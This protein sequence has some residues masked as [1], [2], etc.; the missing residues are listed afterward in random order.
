ME[1][2]LAYLDSGLAAKGWTQYRL[3]QEVKIST[4]AFYRL[5]YGVGQGGM[6]EENLRRVAQA[7]DLDADRLVVL[8]GALYKPNSLRWNYSKLLGENIA[9]RAEL[10][11]LRSGTEALAS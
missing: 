3:A 4:T 5:Y 7:L 2:F 11:R 8:S 9:L 10:D 1:E 6:S